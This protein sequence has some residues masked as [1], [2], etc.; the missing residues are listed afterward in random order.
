M[1][2]SDKWSCYYSF[3]LAISADETSEAVSWYLETLMVFGLCSAFWTGCNIRNGVAK[4][5]ISPSVCRL[6][7]VK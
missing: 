5:P 3:V 7:A 2:L 4:I 6:R 1:F